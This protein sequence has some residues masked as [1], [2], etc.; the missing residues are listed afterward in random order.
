MAEIEQMPESHLQEYQLFYQ[1]Q[2]FGLWREDYRTAQISHLL[3][4]INSDPKKSSSKL[5]EFMP[6]FPTTSEQTQEQVFDDGSEVF[7]ASR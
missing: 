7:L 5:S 4:M 3:A 1:Q 6:F 2:P